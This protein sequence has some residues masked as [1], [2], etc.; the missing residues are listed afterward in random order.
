TPQTAAPRRGVVYVPNGMAMDSW[1][2]AVEGTGF[3]LTPILLSLQPFRDRLIVLSNLRGARGGASHAA[4][5]TRFL[6]GMVARQ[7]RGTGV[8]ANISM[9]QVAAKHFA[10]DTQLA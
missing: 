7:P 8:Q 3:E 1:T 5:A 2:P 4:T 10:Q 6:T 9:D